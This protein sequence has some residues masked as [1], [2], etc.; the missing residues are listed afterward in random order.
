MPETIERSP[1]SRRAS[2]I[3]LLPVLALLSAGGC[4]SVSL[5]DQARLSHPGL[6]FSDSP[7]LAD[8]GSVFSTVEPGTDDR[9]GA[10]ASGCT[11]CR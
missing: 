3:I 9:G 5:S 6:Q 2:L 1:G 7:A 4:A 10:S 11:A 8:T